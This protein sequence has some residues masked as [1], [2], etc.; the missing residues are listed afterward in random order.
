MCHVGPD[1]DT[2][3]IF[4]FKPVGQVRKISYKDCN[5]MMLTKMFVK[6]NKINYV[7]NLDLIKIYKLC[8][9]ID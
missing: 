9:M 3:L 6:D 7:E 8:F 1:R 5:A 4:G 2:P